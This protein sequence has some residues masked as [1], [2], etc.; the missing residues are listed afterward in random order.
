MAPWVSFICE[1]AVLKLA[2]WPHGG[3]FPPAVGAT[4]GCVKIELAPPLT[5]Y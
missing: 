4:R 3:R 2:N 1:E 5:F